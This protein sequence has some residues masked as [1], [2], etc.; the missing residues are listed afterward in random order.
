METGLK[1]EHHSSTCL[2]KRIIE[3]SLFSIFTSL[4]Y[5]VTQS[6]VISSV[7][8][9]L[10]VQS[11]VFSGW[12]KADERREE[13]NPLQ[14]LEDQSFYRSKQTELSNR[15]IHTTSAQYSHQASEWSDS[16]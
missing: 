13:D 10:C 9:L 12:R 15:W 2:Y 6:D 5:A 4:F 16:R 7:N 11:D 14:F 3:Y 8:P 1:H